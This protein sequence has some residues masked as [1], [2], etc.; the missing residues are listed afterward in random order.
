MSDSSYNTNDKITAIDWNGQHFVLTAR[1]EITDG[2][3]SY[4]Y[5][6]D[7]VSWTKSNFYPN[8]TTQNPYSVKF[9]GDKFLVTG[10]LIS[11]SINA[12]GN[13]VTQNC[14]IDIIDGQYPVTIPTN[15]TGNTIVYDIECNL[16]QQHRIV[17]PKTIALVLGNTI[18]YT[19]DQGNTWTNIINSPFSNVVNDAVWNG[20]IWVSVGEGSENT[21]STSLDGVHWVGRG[22]YIFSSSCKGIDWSPQQKNFVAVGSGMNIVATSMDGIYWRGT[23]TTLFSSGG[24]DIKW[25]GHIWVAVGTSSGSTIAYSFDSI[26]WSYSPVSFQSSGLSLYYD[27]VIWTA[28]GSDPSYNIAT[29]SDG[30]NWTLSYV[31]GANELMFTMPTGLF[32]DPS[33][34][35]YPNFTYPIKDC[36]TLSSINKY[37][38]NNSDR[39]CVQ[40]QPISIACGSGSHSIAYS[41]DGI[42]WI[43]INNSL[44]SHCN[45]AIWNGSLWVAVGQGSYWVATSPDGLNWTGR[46]SVLMTECY[47]IA[48]NGSCFV[49][50]GAAGSSRMATSPDGIVWTS[51]SISSV[52]S[53]SIHSIDWTGYVWLA[54]G[55]GTNTTAISYSQDASIWVPTP[56]PNLCVID[57]YNF[58]IGG[59]IDSSAS[60]YQGTDI[61][62]NAFDASFNNTITRWSSENSNYDSSGNYIGSSVT[63]GIS[64]E[65]LQVNLN[66][67]FSCSNY[68][69]VFSIVDG[70]AIPHSWSFLGSSDGIS[71]DL[72][73]TFNYGTS[74]PPNNNWKYPFICLP[75]SINPI[76]VASY[77]YYRIVFTSNF[78]AGNVSVAELSLFNSGEQQSTIH[79]RPVILKD[80]ILH[81]TRILS[82]DGTVPNIYR[83]TDLSCNLIRS[84]VIHNGQYVNNI[85]YGLTT[86]PSASLFDGENH[87]ILSISGEI[88]YISNVASNTNLNFDN[89]MNGVS[90][91]SIN[92]GGSA[93]CYNSKFIL[94]D[95]SYGILNN[96]VPPLFYSNNLSSLFT[97]IKGLASNSGYGFVVS[98]NR[99]YLNDNEQ[100]SLITP[101]FYDSE[102]SSHTSISFNVYKSNE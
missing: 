63:Q 66:A 92:G 97:T 22:N 47:D 95:S 14:I 52:F 21:I 56:T 32:V 70:S 82:V 37:I 88:S 81:P 34:N 76:Q 94:I 16:E 26:T 77:S 33:L 9:L 24:N 29:S 85:M 87:V 73:D 101:K 72:L 99:I 67:S 45:R 89:S 93:A 91:S 15:L 48:W 62:A 74:T 10:N 1:D 31:S 28:Y 90:I 44:F 35:I 12:S 71:W 43:A 79:I 80:V 58:L 98:P 39:G 50:V 51:I 19:F 36:G 18:S 65:W 61:H 6:S 55:E 46:N 86:E 5:S 38:H 84:G 25:N 49:A 41:I 11:S 96:N 20:K 60:S 3:F 59:L 68:Y 53:V 75:L 57:C 83:I 23:N 2:S 78:G 8:V 54:Y 7:G 27:G 100:L 40:I 64:G 17:F 30:M 69:I 4:A 13:T 102:L 42:Q